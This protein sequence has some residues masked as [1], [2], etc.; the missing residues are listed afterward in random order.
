MAARAARGTFSSC[1][2]FIANLAFP[3]RGRR[4]PGH[5]TV[6]T[7]VSALRLG[8]ADHVTKPFVLDDLLLKVRR[9]IEFCAQK[10]ELRWYRQQLQ[11]EY[12]YS[13]LI[14]KSA[15]MREL[16]DLTRRAAGTDSPV[17][18]TGRERNR[19]RTRGPGHSSSSKSSPVVVRPPGSRHSCCGTPPEHHRQT[20]CR[21]S[22]RTA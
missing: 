10:R 21:I 19:Q 1:E 15:A 11:A 3:F 12:D 6:D 13:N 9:T 2:S 5:P 8:A 4:E 17:L 22:H 16:Y 14:G 20:R 7:A 18:I